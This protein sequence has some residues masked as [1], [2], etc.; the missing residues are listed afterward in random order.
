MWIIK[1]FLKIRKINY[2]RNAI[3]VLDNASYHSSKNTRDK[4]VDLCFN[5]KYLPPYSPTFV[6][7]EQLFKLIKSKIRSTESR[8]EIKLS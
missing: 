2:Q 6:L 8:F 4:L 1:Y 3:V 5:A 7:V